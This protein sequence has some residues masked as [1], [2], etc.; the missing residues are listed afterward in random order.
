MQKTIR[1]AP[2]GLAILMLIGP[3]IVWCSEYIG[4]GEVILATRT[5]ALPGLPVIWALRQGVSANAWGEIL[6]LI[7]WGAGGFASQVWYTYW[8]LGAGY[9]MAEK[10]N[11]GKAASVERLKNIEVSDAHKIKSWFR[12]V[13][14]DA[15]VAMVI[16]IFVT[17]SF[18]I[19]GAGI[20]GKMEIAPDQETLAAQLA[21]VFQSQWGRTGAVLFIAGGLAALISTQIGQL[22]GWP[23][24][25]ADAFRICIPRFARLKWVIQF[26][27]FLVF[28]FTSNMIIVYSLGYKPVVLVKMGAILDGLLLTPFQA[29]WVIAGLYIV[30]PK[31]FKKE[32]AEILKPKWYLAAGLFIAF[33]VFTYYCVYQ[34]PRII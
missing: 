12:V 10:D 22:A 18:L 11:Y 31:L 34:V 4:S 21:Q 26:R 27:F 19:A 9:G 24:L 23:R 20:L 8:V 13:Y 25:L 16:G 17:V 6:P 33:I 29:L 32:V 30:Q 28:F 14:M 3:S 2:A 5:G 1:K 15:S 7:G